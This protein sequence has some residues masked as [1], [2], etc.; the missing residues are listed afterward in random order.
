MGP[1]ALKKTK[2]WMEQGV[3]LPAFDYESLERDMLEKE[4]AETAKEARFQHHLEALFG[5][6]AESFSPELRNTLKKL[7]TAGL[8]DG[9]H[10][11]EEDTGVRNTQ[12]ERDRLAKLVVDTLKKSAILAP[13]KDET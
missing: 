13:W 2:S 11:G 5:D 9:E 3:F 8:V 10:G 6:R 4:A 7:Y 12:E 1:D